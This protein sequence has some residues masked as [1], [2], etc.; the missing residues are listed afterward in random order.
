MQA[1]HFSFL[2]LQLRPN[3]YLIPSVDRS[4][5]LGPFFQMTAEADTAFRLLTRP[6]SVPIVAALQSVGEFSRV[7]SKALTR[8]CFSKSL[9][10]LR[11]NGE[12]HA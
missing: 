3:K 1:P 6:Q 10:V 9:L 11:T 2:Q 7:F 4:K 8:N 5:H 12:E